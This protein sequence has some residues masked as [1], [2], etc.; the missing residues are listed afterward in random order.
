MK[1]TG[2]AWCALIAGGLALV[3]LG[4]GL[5]TVLGGKAAPRKAPVPSTPPPV[6]SVPESQPAPAPEASVSPPDNPAAPP[7]APS[8][9]AAPAG[10]DIGLDAAKDTALSRAGVAPELAS[11]TEL[12]TEYDNGRLEYKLEFW[13]SQVE[14][15]YEI[16]GATGEITKEKWENHG[17]TGSTEDLGEAAAR[18]AALA[19]AGLA[20]NQVA[21]LKTERE[22]ENGL[23]EYEIEFWV[24]RE[25]Y[26]YE[27]S[28]A[29]NI[30]KYKRE[31]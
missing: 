17:L 29:G 27:I 21:A 18:A 8:G 6:S 5:A 15:E 19:H 4:A 9:S 16:D 20:E 1:L 10:G 13:A 14:Y 23:V 11:W 31:R 30:L 7:P 12:D 25:E 22:L 24:G 3:L 2:K 28:G 26:E